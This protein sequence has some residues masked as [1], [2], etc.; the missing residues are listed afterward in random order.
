MVLALVLVN[1]N[2]PV[3]N[4]VGWIINLYCVLVNDFDHEFS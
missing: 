2:N 4:T 1:D 3:T